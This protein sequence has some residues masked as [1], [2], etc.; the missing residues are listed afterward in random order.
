MVFASKVRTARLAWVA[1]ALALAPLG[2][3]ACSSGDHGNSPPSPIDTSAPEVGTVVEPKTHPVVQVTM[4]ANDLGGSSSNTKETFLNVDNVNAKQFGKLF[5]VPVDGDQYAQPLYMG[6]LKMSDGKTHNVVFVATEHD[7]VY[8]FDADVKGTPLWKVSVGTSTPVPAPWF[9]AIISPEIAC[10]A[11]VFN[12]RE[13]G[14]TSTPVIDTATQTLYVVALNADASNSIS[15]PTCVHTNP[16]DK[17]DCE[18]YTC[19]QPA[20]SYRLHALDLTTGKERSGS[21]VTITA[22]VSGTGQASSNG[23]ITFDART[24]LQRPSLLLD[25][26]TIY[27]AMASYGDEAEYHGW[28]FAYDAATLDQKAVILDSP[29]GEKGGIWMSGRHMLSDHK[30]YVYL[31]TGNGTFDANSGGADYGDSV[32]KLDAKTLKVVDWFSPFLS[33][34][35]GENLLSDFDT[36][37][38]SAGATL[39]PNTTLLLATGKTGNG[40][41]I[42][43]TNMGHWTANRDA[44]AQTVHLTWL[45]NQTA[46]D[47]NGSSLLDGALIYGTP[48]TW[49]GPDGTHVY[50]WGSSDYFRDYLLEKNGH[51]STHGICFCNAG[52]QVV[53]GGTTYTID[54][55]DPPC[56]VPASE[57]PDHVIGSPGGIASV[58]SNGTEVG[59]GIVW[60]THPVPFGALWGPVAGEMEAFNA[61]YLTQPLW[62]SNDNAARDSAGNWGKYTPPT[63]ANGKVYL[64]T[65]SNE[66]IVYGLLP[67]P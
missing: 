46:C 16:S 12:T 58:S 64:A 20:I 63:I 25:Y 51:F 17:D 22:E 49:S 10:V 34:Y 29:D 2:L 66:L 5:T 50:V 54:A 4:N 37:L 15:A 42:D 53:N 40:Y 24:H 28:I 31:V 11:H 43:T 35:E 33:D 26:G 52:W 14:I 19:D 59:T 30:G 48:A 9:G 23:K 45:Y 57:S 39:I 13:S 67:T 65:Q 8:A 27:F 18:T 38:G 3:L 56:G 6:G 60:A 21:P 1:S 32:L 47:A 55:P 44:I 7:S 41:V 61:T 36:D 62:T